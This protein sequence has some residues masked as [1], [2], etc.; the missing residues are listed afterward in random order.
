MNGAWRQSDKDVHEAKAEAIRV[1][2]SM[3]EGIRDA[4]S[5]P[6]DG[7][8]AQLLLG[9]QHEADRHE[10]AAKLVSVS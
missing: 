8:I 1:A 4:V 7:M 6:V 3:I 2:A 10:Q 9:L 5:T